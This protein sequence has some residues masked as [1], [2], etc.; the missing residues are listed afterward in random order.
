MKTWQF[1]E[2]GNI[3]MSQFFASERFDKP[4]EQTPRNLGVGTFGSQNH[5]ENIL[6]EHRNS[7]EVS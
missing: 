1:L 4:S 7:Q 3:Q 2:N 5:H 6:P